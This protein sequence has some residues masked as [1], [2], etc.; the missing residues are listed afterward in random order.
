VA[1]RHVGSK[2]ATGARPGQQQYSI[3]RCLSIELFTKIVTSRILENG[4]LV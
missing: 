1:G 4:A 2:L 3:N